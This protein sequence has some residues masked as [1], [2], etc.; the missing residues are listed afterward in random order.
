[1]ASTELTHAQISPTHIDLKPIVTAPSQPIVKPLPAQTPGWQRSLWAT[2]AAAFFVLMAAQIALGS[3]YNGRVLPGVKVADVDLSN[4]NRIQARDLLIAR[5]QNHKIKLNIAEKALE[6]DP[7]EVGAKYDINTTIDQAFLQGRNQW[8]MPLAIWQTIHQ[9]RLNYAFT[10]DGSIQ[11]PLVTKLVESSGQAPVDASITVVN[12]NPLVKADSNGVA[13]SAVDIAAAIAQ[14]VSDIVQPP[15]SLQPKVQPARIQAKDVT[16]AIDQTK[17]FLKVPVTITFQGRNFNPSAAQM[18]DWF[19]YEKSPPDQ[20]AGL[21]TK[22]SSD[23]IKHYLQSVALQINI[24]PTNKKIR[25]ENGVMSEVQAGKDGQQLDQDSL[26][27]QIV[28][29]VSSKQ[30]FSGEA[31]VI[32][33]PFQT[34]YNR[35]VTLDYGK[36]I[37]VNLK[38]QHMWVYQDHQV[39]F[40]SP[41]TS[42]ATGAGFPTVTGLFSVLAKQTNRNLNGYAIGYNYNVFVKYWMP[43]YG[44]YGLHDASWRA[45]FG[46]PDY[47][48]GGSHGC[49]NMPEASAAFLFGWT[50]VGTPVW[51]HN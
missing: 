1:M 17:S 29:A 38:L 23:G 21:V 8:F 36:Y 41:I 37:E 5:V 9:S 32:P 40:E 51:V 22:I 27:T 20:P 33:V 43:F 47:Y 28:K 42:G 31:Q 6:L 4:L 15:A 25:V 26:A 3:W 11:N 7:N 48:Y 39:I 12:G 13:I 35:V 45:A 10:V 2:G 19:T 50:D 16:A 49:V 18:S 44:N 34:E 14:Q 30:S 24:N 46:G